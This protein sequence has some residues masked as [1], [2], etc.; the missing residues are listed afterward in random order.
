VLATT[1]AV[2]GVATLDLPWTLIIGVAAAALAVTSVTSV[3]T[4]W[5]ATRPSPVALLGARE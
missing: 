5:S 1:S 2:T 4:S 3:L